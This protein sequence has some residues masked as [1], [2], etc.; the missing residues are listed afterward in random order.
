[1]FIATTWNC[2]FRITFELSE[3]FCIRPF[4]YSALPLTNPFP[5]IFRTYLRQEKKRLLLNYALKA[6]QAQI[7]FTVALLG[8]QPCDGLAA[9]FNPFSAHLSPGSLFFT[10]KT[11]FKNPLQ[12]TFIIV[13]LNPII[14]VALTTFTDKLRHYLMRLALISCIKD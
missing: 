8:I 2:S 14:I 7:Y 6:T 4:N 9:F 10:L 5:A 12:C 1:M 13:T 3:I 11:S